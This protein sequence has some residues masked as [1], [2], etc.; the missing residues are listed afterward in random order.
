MRRFGGIN[1]GAV[2]T[3][4]VLMGYT[5]LTL[6]PVLLVVMNS[7]KTRR[8]IFRDP[9]MPPTPATFSL[10]GYETAFLRG[11]FGLYFLNS[12]IVTVVSLFVILAVGL[13]AAHAIV[14]SSWKGTRWIVLYFAVGLMIP[15]RLATVSLLQMIAGMDLTNSLTGLVIVYSAQGVPLSI[16][17]LSEFLRQLPQSLKDAAR[18]DG[19]DEYRILFQ[20]ILPLV[21][22]PMA[23]VAIFSMMPIW[24]DLWFPL[25]LAPGNSTLTVTLGAQKFLGEFVSDWNAV[26]AALTVSALP[27]LG[28]YMLFSRQFIRGITSG[29]VK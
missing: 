2:A 7:F 15:I 8:A 6:A 23:T 17:V 20:I 10:G 1:A 27:V 25:I 26:L 11:D 16:L 3:H 13:M 9:L 19:A 18:I 12:T 24:N 29:A 5:V 22:A 4:C 28:I 21:R 14:E